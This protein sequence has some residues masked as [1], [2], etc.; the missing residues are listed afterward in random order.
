MHG[1]D[2]VSNAFEARLP[3]DSIRAS[4]RLYGAGAPG[5]MGA[6]PL[7]PKRGGATGA[8]TGST[9]SGEAKRDRPTGHTT[10]TATTSCSRSHG[11]GS[12]ESKEPRPRVG[13]AP[14]H[15]SLMLGIQTSSIQLNLAP[16]SLTHSRSTGGFRDLNSNE[17][18]MSGRFRD[19]KQASK[20][21]G[22]ANKLQA[23]APFTSLSYFSSSSMKRERS[24]T[25]TAATQRKPA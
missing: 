25:S 11:G 7:P 20:S 9:L 1:Q 19:F 6:W 18:S 21:E 4:H 2:L 24:D 23:S 8:S 17:V 12:I 13:E 10:P 15:G 16:D 22:E 5:A 3:R 14:M